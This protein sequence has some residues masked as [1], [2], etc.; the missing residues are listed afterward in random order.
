MNFYGHPHKELLIRLEN[1]DSKILIT[2]ETGAI[3]IK[4]N[5]KKMKVEEFLRR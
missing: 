2:Y 1:M 4:T 3:T 5:G